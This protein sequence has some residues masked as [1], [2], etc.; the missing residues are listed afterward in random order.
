MKA[1]LLAACVLA[2]VIGCNEQTGSGGSH[3]PELVLDGANFPQRVLQSRQPVLVDFFS[4]RC[5]P[6]LRMAPI[7]AQVATDFQG[8]AVVGKVDTDKSTSLAEQYQITAVPTFIFFKN[9][10]VVDRFTL[11]GEQSK[12]TLAARLEALV[13]K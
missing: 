13:D 6:C 8:K 4:T 7:V 12:E 5:P 2:C 10:A 3:G 1:R 9:G 11:V